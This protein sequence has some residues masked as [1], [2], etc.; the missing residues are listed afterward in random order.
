[1][2]EHFNL[3]EQARHAAFVAFRAERY[4][5]LRDARL[6]CLAAVE[7]KDDVHPKISVVCP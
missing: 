6:Q 2:P 3:G 1:V 4:A 5:E 7:V